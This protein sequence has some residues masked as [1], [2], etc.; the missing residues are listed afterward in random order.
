M[1]SLRLV[2]VS[3]GSNTQTP[4]RR[5]ATMPDNEPEPQ[6]PRWTDRPGPAS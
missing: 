6:S 2:T 3:V 4:H 1:V 5:E